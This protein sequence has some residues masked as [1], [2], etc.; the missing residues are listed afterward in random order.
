M[1]LARVL[2]RDASGA[3]AAL[4]RVTEL[5]PENP[6][7]HAYLAFVYLY[8]WR[9][10]AAAAPLK[11]ALELAPQSQEIQILAAVGALM[12]GNPFQTWH[13]LQDFIPSGVKLV[14]KF[15]LGASL[16]LVIVLIIL[17]ITKFMKNSSSIKI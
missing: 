11:T 10:F 2:R 6:Y 15:I 17:M 5:D 8:D 7:A 1:S 13:Y 9:P 16:L 14:V 3:A 4:Q 12:R